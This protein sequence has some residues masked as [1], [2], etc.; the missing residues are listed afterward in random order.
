VS[1]QLVNNN[2]E[3]KSNFIMSSPIGPLSQ[4]LAMFMFVGLF[5]P[6]DP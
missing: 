4:I 1:Q 2:W 3:Y 5:T 6:L